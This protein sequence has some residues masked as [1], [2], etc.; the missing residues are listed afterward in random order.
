[1]NA[2]DA[3]RRLLLTGLTAVSLGGAVASVAAPLPP[4]AG[5]PAAPAAVRLYVPYGPGGESDAS[6]QNFLNSAARQSPGRRL[7]AM[8]LIADFGGAAG[9]AV[10]SAPAD[11]SVLLL[12]R[13]GNVIIQPTLTPDTAPPLGEFTVLALL[14][15]AP[16]ICIVRQSSAIKSLRDLQAAVAA[17]PGRLRYAT[18]G[19]SSL[20]GVA[21]RYLLH[22][23][24]LPTDA[25]RP[26]HFTQGAQITQAVVN[27]EAD[28]ACNSPRSVLPLVASGQL[29]PLLTTA[30]GRLKA[31]PRLQN[32]AELG[33]RDMQQLQAWSALLGPARMPAI[34]V[35]HWQALLV[36]VADDP[37]WQAAIEALGAVPR[38]RAVP[39]PAQFLRQQALFYERLVTT[40]GER[41]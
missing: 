34:A 35:A 28:F 33:L 25:A 8:H 6:A 26:V 17:A 20:Q 18:A 32:A 21:V 16:L 12:G 19:P 14:D 38:L 39:D 40:L 10:Q 41:P 24:G 5:R 22:L 2:S 15:Q 9:R 13:V 29:R 7:E 30:Q 31:L 23:S 1:M 36:R 3:V 27:G 37:E 4:G 11:G